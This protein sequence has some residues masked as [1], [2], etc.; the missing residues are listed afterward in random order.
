MA[1]FDDA[2]KRDLAVSAAME[3]GTSVNWVGNITPV[4]SGGR[5]SEVSRPFALF[6]GNRLSPLAFMQN[7]ATS[8]TPA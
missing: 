8:C 3:T 7:G 1:I 5:I 6:Q 2:Q 4:M